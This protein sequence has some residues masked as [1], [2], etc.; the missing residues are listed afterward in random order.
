M[1][2]KI[3][4][5]DDDPNIVDYLTSFLED[6]GYTVNSATDAEKGLEMVKNDP[7]RFD[8]T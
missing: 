8:N 6:N 2:K 7:P 5:I 3:Q 1:S 4:V